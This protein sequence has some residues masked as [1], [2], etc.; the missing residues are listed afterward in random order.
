MRCLFRLFLSLFG[1]VF[2]AVGGFMLFTVFIDTPDEVTATLGAL[3]TLERAA[4]EEEL[5]VF[6]DGQTAGSNSFGGAELDEGD[7]NEV[8]AERPTTTEG[9]PQVDPN[10]IREQANSV[11]SPEAVT[12]TEV[13]SNP[14]LSNEPINA[15]TNVVVEEV[16]GTEEIE[17]PS[18]TGGGTAN[19]AT[20]QRVAELEWPE[21]FRDGESGSIRLTLRALEEGGLVA[22]AEI[23]EN[24]ILATPIILTD[25]YDTHDAFITARISAPD[26]EIE[27]NSSAQQQMFEGERVEWR[28]TLTPNDTG[29]FVI[30]V[31]TEVI[32]QPK[33]PGT[34]VTIGPLP[35]WGQSVQSDVDQV[36]GLISIPQASIAGTIIAVIGALLELPF[37][38]ELGSAFLERMVDRIRNGDKSGNR[39]RRA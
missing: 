32:W 23:D 15:A 6:V 4:S 38:A 27:G 7:I 1:I 19:F 5:N 17:A 31:G 3:T 36:F 12:N 9:R 10:E 24:T 25:R 35:V 29:S 39:S 28:W 18:G 34:G 26:F 13:L 33:D 14:V 20:E 16:A 30:T 37:F 11:I 2:L 8:I 21:K 22:E